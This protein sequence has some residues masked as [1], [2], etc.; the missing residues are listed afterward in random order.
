MK[1]FF[2]KYKLLFAI[3]YVVVFFVIGLLKYMEWR[4]TGDILSLV[5]TIMSLILVVIKFTTA[6]NIIKSK[7]AHT[8]IDN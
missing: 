1:S 5:I 3:L 6:Y 2:Q 7:R 8:H 4:S